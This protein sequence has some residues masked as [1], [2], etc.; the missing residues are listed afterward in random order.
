MM[1]GV[2]SCSFSRRWVTTR[3]ISCSRISCRTRSPNPSPHSTCHVDQAYI[4]P[5]IDHHASIT[6]HRSPS[7]HTNI[8]VLISATGSG[9]KEEWIIKKYRDFAFTRQDVS[10]FLQRTGHTATAD[11][12]P[13]KAGFLNKQGGQV[14]TWKRRYVQLYAGYMA[15]FKA[16]G[17]RRRHTI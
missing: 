5:C 6:I 2:R 15:Y 1:D 9:E 8:P 3:P 7:V 17:V 13:I 11:E 4:E 16:P 10:V 14:K 12:V